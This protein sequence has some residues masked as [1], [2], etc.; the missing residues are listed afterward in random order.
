MEPLYYETTFFLYYETTFLLYVYFFETLYV[1]F[2]PFFILTRLLLLLILL[3]FIEL[4]HC[5]FIKYEKNINQSLMGFRQRGQLD[6]F[7]LSKQVVWKTCPQG[8]RV[9]F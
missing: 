7:V 5:F 4:L 3:N 1:F 2:Y 9:T 8:N 6:N